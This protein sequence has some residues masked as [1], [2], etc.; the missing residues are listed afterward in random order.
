[1]LEFIQ[2]D[3]KNLSPEEWDDFVEVSDNGTMFNKR[4]FLS[5]HDKS[6]FKD[7]SFFAR[8][9][10]KLFSV[11]TAAIIERD[12]KKILAS[13]PGASYG[14]FVYP[15]DLNFDYA[16]LPFKLGSGGT[17]LFQRQIKF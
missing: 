17:N 13:H 1:M 4:S 12:G 6:K 11:F 7:A 8:K 10:G 14:S 16:F 3:G 15:S 9:N 2:Y 5:Y